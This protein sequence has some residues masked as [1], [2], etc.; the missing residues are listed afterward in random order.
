MLKSLLRRVGAVLGLSLLLGS[1][2]AEARVPQ[3]ARP[4]LWEISDPDTTI[5]LFG[6][7]HL[8]PE[9]FQWRTPK[10]NQAVASSQQLVV[11]TIVDDKNPAKLMSAMAAL[12]F[13]NGLPPLSQRVPAAKRP[14]LAAAIKSSGFPPQAFDRMKT[15]AAA[16]ILLG[17]K[18]REL[19]L[20]GG[21]GVEQVLR[22][23]FSGAGKPV[24]E[25]ESNVEQLTFFDKLPESAQLA[26]LEGAIEDGK[27][28]DA[29]FGGMIRAWSRGDVQGIARTFDR[30]L[31]ESPALQ[32]SLIHQ[33]N[34]NWS[35]W[36]EQRM[37]QPGAILIAVGA[38]HLAGK[39]S[40]LEMLKKDG[41]KVRRLQ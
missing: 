41:Y 12:G 31:S 6:T 39:D 15:W 28:M 8:L 11:E 3:V 10:F 37:S 35:K 26:L 27:S 32:R 20:K 14:E 2:P 1:V 30:D 16:F 36:I 4:A 9:N 25:L 18:F 29:E 19:G 17:N 38:G 40:V 21:E 7:I 23:D 34:T 24:G 22:S 33:R 13:A 5:Y